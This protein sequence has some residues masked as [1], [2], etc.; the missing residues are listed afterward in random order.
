M[1]RAIAV[2]SPSSVLTQKMEEEIKKR[3]LNIIVRQSFTDDAIN[4][5]EELILRGTKVL[6]SRGHT[7]SVL[8]QN[9]DI[10]IVDVRHTFF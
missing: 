9:L 10:P 2:I 1:D 3:N 4:E 8:R 6:I 5:A 7:A